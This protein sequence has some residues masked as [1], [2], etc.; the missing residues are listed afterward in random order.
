MKG[1][2]AEKAGLMR[3]DRILEIGGTTLKTWQD[4]TA[5]IHAS[6]DK[7]MGFTIQRGEQVMEM[8][9]TPNKE[10]YKTPDGEEKEIGLSASNPLEMIS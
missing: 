8:T 10:T 9:I 6:P 3:G 7:P 1:S 5:L 2:R 4:M